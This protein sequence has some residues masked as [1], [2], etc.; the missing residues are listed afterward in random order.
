MISYKL[1]FTALSLALADSIKVAEVYLSCND[2]ITTNEILI[3][4]NILQSRTI[5]R[6]KRVAREL[7]L[8]LSLLTSDQLSLLVEGSFEEQKL[9][10]WF[11][12]CKTYTII[13]DFATEVLHEKFLVMDRHISGNDINIFFLQKI[14]SHVELEK[15]TENTKK[16]LLSQIF[17]MLQEADLVN[18][19]GQIIRVIPSRRLA[20]VLRPDAEFA[21]KIYPAFTEEFT[22]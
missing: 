21:Y 13:R 1:S 12:V 5:S 9:L 18:S 10:L 14:D 8:R 15:I 4:N 22:L 3:N 20:I 7:I 11:A 6:G 2:W 17:H 19:S 16:K